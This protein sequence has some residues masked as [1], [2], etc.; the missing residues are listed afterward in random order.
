LPPAAVT[1]LVLSSLPAGTAPTDPAVEAI[2]GRAAGNPFFVTELLRLSP[3]ELVAATV[4][5]GV[6]DVIRQRLDQLPE[7][8]VQVLRIAAVVGVEF[9][10]VT[11]EAAG[12]GDAT[13]DAVELAVD[14]ALVEETDVIGRYR[15][16]HALVQEVLAA[17]L[18]GLRRAR[19][20]ATIAAAMPWPV[21]AAAPGRLAELAR[22]A[23]AGAAADPDTA[24]RAVEVSL[25]ASRQAM[26][27]LGYEAAAAHCERALSAV[28]AGAEVSAEAEGSLL[29]ALATA[30][31]AVGDPAGSRAACLQAAELA[32]RA[33]DGELLACAALGLAL[34]GAVIGMDFG[35]VDHTRVELLEEALSLL[36]AA[37][38]PTRVRLLAHLALALQLGGDEGRRQEAADEA[39]AVA[40][41][42]GA[43]GLRARRWRRATAPC[44]DRRRWAT[45]CRRRATCLPWPRP[46]A[47]PRPRSRR[48]SRSPS[49]CSRPARCP[50][51]RR[52]W[53]WCTR[54]PPSSASRSTSGTAG[55]WRR[56]WPPWRVATATRSSTPTRRQRRAASP[57]AG[58]RTGVGS[59]GSTSRHGTWACCRRSSC[60]SGASPAPSRAAPS[61]RP[62]SPTSS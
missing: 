5:D 15:F 27:D 53:R 50:R 37:D 58:G 30:R 44:G 26:E 18:G 45:A 4:P 42:L 39:V 48:T 36:P 23:C 20:H 34:P 52:R 51:S 25:E 22:H 21:P 11:V 28:A 47:G 14:L 62:A 17:S 13:L 7:A 56:R 49:T 2:V 31:R 32:R 60:R 61:C 59:A 16:A 46:A 38:T 10:V 33:G 35:L 40:E 1:E 6:R 57:S 54:A 9:D 12:G 3:D 41:R 8:V 24:A 19:L 43:P 29:V 55:S